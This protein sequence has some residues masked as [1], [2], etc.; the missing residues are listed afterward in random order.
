MAAFFQPGAIEFKKHQ[1]SVDKPCLI[2]IHEN[3]LYASDP[4]QI[5][6]AVNVQVNGNT[7]QLQLPDN[8]FTTKGIKVKGTNR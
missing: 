5:N 4:Q 2:M 1:V 7:Y 3:N 6:N 8:G